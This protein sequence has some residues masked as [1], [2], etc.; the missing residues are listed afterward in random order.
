M[1][2]TFLLITP[3]KIYKVEEELLFDDA[4][5]ALRYKK[6]IRLP[7]PDLGFIEGQTNCLKKAF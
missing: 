6:N 7:F 2:I 1:P 5:E 3:I 4:G